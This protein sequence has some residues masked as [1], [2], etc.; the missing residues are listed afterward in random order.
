M[1]APSWTPPAAIAIILI[2]AA[3]GGSPTSPSNAPRVAPG[4]WAFL[5]ASTTVG[6]SASGLAQTWV[7]RLQSAVSG[8]GVTIVNLA[9]AGATSYTWMPAA[10]PVPFGR[11]GP[12][13]PNNIDAAMTHRPSLVLLNAT[14]NDLVAN[15]SVDEL[16][17]NLLAIRGVASAGGAAVVMLSTQ[18]RNLSDAAR[19]LLPVIDARLSPVFGECFVDIRTPLAAPDG[20]MLPLYDVGDGIHPNDAGHAV[21]FQRVDATLQSGRCVAAVH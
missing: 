17:A 15:Y 1:P 11:F 19:A 4:T 5:G 10:A 20:R 21:I 2:A 14:N 13:L 7:A 16:V 8:R 6:F 18:P 9:L 12:S 3:C